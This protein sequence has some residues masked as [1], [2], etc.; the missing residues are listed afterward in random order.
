MCSILTN[1]Y[2]YFNIFAFTSLKS[3]ITAMEESSNKNNVDVYTNI[4]KAGKRTYFFD[5]KLTKSG[6]KYLTITESKRR[7]DEEQ[8]KFIYEK[9]K[10]FLYREDFEN[11][12]QGLSGA[13]A[14][15][16]A[17]GKGFDAELSAAETNNSS[18]LTAE[19]F[20]L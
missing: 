13:V 2:N 11:F 16:D 9:H 3:Q 18:D 10:I 6:E 1:N 15:I 19:D 4:I 20:G 5:V 17:D 8:D 7:Y 14:F 12:I